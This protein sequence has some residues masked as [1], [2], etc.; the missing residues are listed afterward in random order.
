MLTMQ[1][2]IVAT[3]PPN[4][5]PSTNANAIMLVRVAVGDT[6]L[7]S[8]ERLA[9]ETGV[10]VAAVGGAVVA[11]RIEPSGARGGL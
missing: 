1:S 6:D 3:V 7:K 10:V 5:A 9:V 2:P 11:H 4:S 8:V